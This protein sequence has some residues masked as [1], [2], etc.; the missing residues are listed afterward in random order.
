MRMQQ[1]KTDV[2]RMATKRMDTAK[3]GWVV[4]EHTNTNYDINWLEVY[5]WR[6]ISQS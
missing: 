6:A 3:T 4:D 5:A 1:T 2:N